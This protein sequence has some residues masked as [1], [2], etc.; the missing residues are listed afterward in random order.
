[1]NKNI[2]DMTE[3]ELKDFI[4][5]LQE[6]NS[7]YERINQKYQEVIEKAIDFIDMHMYEDYCYVG[8]EDRL[9]EILEYN[10]TNYNKKIKN[11]KK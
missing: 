11:T 9:K 1:M 10:L 8:S 6:E 2:G 7:R 5:E 3:S 4:I